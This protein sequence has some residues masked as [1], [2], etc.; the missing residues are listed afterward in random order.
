MMSFSSN[1]VLPTMLT[2]R[3]LARSPSSIWIETRTRLS[4][5]GL[6][7]RRDLRRVLAAAVVLLG[8]RLRQLIERRA[9]EGLAR[10]EP[11]LGQHL[12]EVVVLDVL[13]AVERELEDRRALEHDDHERV[14]VAA[15]LEVLEERRLEQRATRFAQPP[16]VDRVADVDRQIVVDRALGDALRAFDAEVTHDERLER[17]QRGR[18]EPAR[19]AQQRP[20]AQRERIF[21]NRT[22]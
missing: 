15:E 17:G 8:Q 1:D 9:I 18:A 4:S 16:L 19:R 20:T 14:A 12:L 13:V 2:W 5:S 21:M 7:G 6:D 22:T 10:R 11:V 3:I